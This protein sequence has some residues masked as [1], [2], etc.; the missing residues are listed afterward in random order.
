MHLAG[1]AFHRTLL[2]GAIFIASAIFAG[3]IAEKVT[4]KPFF[5]LLEAVHGGSHGVSDPASG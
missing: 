5:E 4:G 1:N 3:T 2:L